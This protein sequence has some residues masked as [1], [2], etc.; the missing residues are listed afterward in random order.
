M[1]YSLFVLLVVKSFFLIDFFWRS[2]SG[3]RVGDISLGNL[4]FCVRMFVMM[5]VLVLK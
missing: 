5:F 4:F 3:L 1:V 2:W